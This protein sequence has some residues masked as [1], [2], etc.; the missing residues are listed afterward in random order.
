ML[1]EYKF[2]SMSP[3]VTQVED[4]S[5]GTESVERVQACIF[6]VGDDCRQDVLALQVLAISL[7]L[8]YP[9]LSSFMP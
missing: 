8:A 3:S 6:K 7:Q 1:V 4:S 2:Q 9:D 5:S